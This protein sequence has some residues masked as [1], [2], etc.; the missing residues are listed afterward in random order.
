[1]HRY[2]METDPVSGEGYDCM[3]IQ[4]P[5]HVRREDK[6]T[7]ET[8][9]AETATLTAPSPRSDLD[10]FS[11][12]NILD[13]YGWNGKFRDTA[14]L[15]WL[16]KY[17]V[18]A[19]GKYDLAKEILDDWETYC[20]SA[21][22]G[23]TNF[24]KEEPWRPPSKL[25]EAD[26]PEHTQR[27][28]VADGVMSHGNLRN[29]RPF[30]AEQA[31]LLVDRLLEK[32]TVDGMA[33]IAQPFILKV[34]PDSVGLK[35][36]GRERLLA[37]GNMVFNGFGPR[38]EIFEESTAAAD[39][40]VDYIM[41]CCLRSELD[42]D[43]LGAQAYKA[44]DEGIVTE[45]EALFI[46][47]SMLSAGLDTTVFAIGNALNCFA[48]HPAEWAKLR[49]KPAL[50]R[51]AVE[52]VLRYDSPFQALF[53]T[54]TREVELAGK[55]IPEK[56]KILVVLGSANRDP[57]AWDDPETFNIDRN[58]AAHLGFGFGIHHC[59]GQAMARLEMQALFTELANRV[60]RIEPAGPGVR[61]VN[62]T[63]HGFKTL[64]LGLT[65]A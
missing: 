18:W 31:K 16:T 11:R 9:M 60:D 4:G 6:N 1:M 46:V 55:T 25:L 56:E 36:E 5:A 52:E 30:F 53:R 59:M 61:A 50:A 43:G 35:P 41:T 20:S 58:A 42:P 51:N 62:N 57:D 44:S 34:F 14:P 54:T 27:R 13:P 48:E 39:E 40:V 15:V 47:R 2:G 28:G 32:G 3:S 24:H 49:E 65:A 10:P 22:V 37:Y 29:L 33:D 21:G 8:D 63:L 38:N 17:D 26:P 12:E 23:L 7:G 19:T 64:P 45:E